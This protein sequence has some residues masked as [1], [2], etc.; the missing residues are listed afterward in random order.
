MS[1]ADRF[2]LDP[3]R[4]WL[5]SAHQ[6]AIPK[7]AAAAAHE[8][9]EWKLRPQEL[10]AERFDGVPGRLRRALAHAVHAKED[11]IFLANGASHGL[12]LIANSVSLKR[13]DEVLLMQDDF[14]SNILPW[15]R[16]E[17]E[18][19]TV[20]RLQPQRHVLQVDEVERALQ[21]NTRLLCVSWVHSF[22]GWA[23]DI[24]AIG[25][26]CRKRGVRFVVNGTQAVG[27]RACDL[28]RLPID[29]LVAAGWKWLCGP[30][31]V[32]FGWL[33]D[34]FRHELAP[35]QRYWLSQQTAE[36]LARVIDPVAAA[37]VDSARRFDL[38]ATANFFNFHTWGAAVDLLQEIGFD[39]IGAHNRQ[40]IAT[41]IERLDSRCRI[42]SPS[43]AGES[44]LFLFEAES[45][46]TTKTLYSALSERGFDTA[47]RHGRIRVAP[48][49]YN[50]EQQLEALASAI[51][52]E[53]D[54]A[55]DG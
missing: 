40:L 49:L 37:P 24:E 30:Y 6:G 33:R 4:V 3:A 9:I 55:L 8:A 53:L 31:G 1:W 13:G 2:G 27:Y 36:D 34:E 48:H 10:T 14:P 19:V 11:E 23:T 16:R 51:S 21:P 35:T 28:S 26:L 12:H 29:A 46:A 18:G 50:D 45:A 47:Y 25:T 5:N 38:F 17:D 54:V 39:A 52:E 43:E 15:V 32:G 20:R 7:V 22:S 44:S 41:M 42:Y